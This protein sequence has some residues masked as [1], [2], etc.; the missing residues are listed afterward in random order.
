MTNRPDLST[1]GSILADVQEQYIELENSNKELNPLDLELLEATVQFMAA[2][3][4][5]LRRAL[6]ENKVNASEGVASAAST[7][8]MESAYLSQEHENVQEEEEEEI[9]VAETS[10]FDEEEEGEVVIFDD[11]DREDD[12]EFDEDEDE[13]DDIEEEEIDFVQDEEEFAVEDEDLGEEEF[14]EEEQNEED[15]ELEDEGNEVNYLH[16]DDVV[17]EDDEEYEELFV[18]E[19]YEAV[20]ADDEKLDENLDAHT[21]FTEKQVDLDEQDEYEENSKD[22]DV[23][24]AEEF[25]LFAPKFDVPAASSASVANTPNVEVNPTATASSSATRDDL[26]GGSPITSAPV[27][28]R[29]LSVNEL[30]GAQIQQSASA[31]GVPNRNEQTRITDLKAAISLNDKLL[32]I[33]DLFNGYSLAYSEAIEILNRYDNIAEA[34]EFLKS[35]YSVKNNWAAK[36]DTVDKFYSILHRRYTK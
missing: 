13:E 28:P 6:L 9:A 27:P 14:D 10:F 22:E 35:N 18:D 11:L 1:I 4:S 16:L 30:F 36:P 2:N 21:E 24:D 34:D 17:E 33:K 20:D 8:K 23:S 12:E 7:Q 5:V 26:F 25:P 29:P 19:T 31:A 3:V 15:D 32:F